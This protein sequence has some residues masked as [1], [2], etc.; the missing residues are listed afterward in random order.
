MKV[1]SVL[2]IKFMSTKHLR[3]CKLKPVVQLI[4]T[5]SGNILTQRTAIRCSNG[6][7]YVALGSSMGLALSVWEGRW[8]VKAG[9]ILFW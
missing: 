3:E 8:S 9:F 2:K 5:K 4:T 1:Q 7:F 6:D